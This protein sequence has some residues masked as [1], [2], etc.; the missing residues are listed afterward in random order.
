MKIKF[1]ISILILF[2]ISTKI[3]SQTTWFEKDATWHY[4][5]SSFWEG[6]GYEKMTYSKDT[7]IQGKL[8]YK[9]NRAIKFIS[10]QF[11]DTIQYQLPPQMVHLSGDT[12][13]LYE[14][15][16]FSQLYNF[17]LR[18]GDTVSFMIFPTLQKNKNIVSDIQTIKINNENLKQQTITVYSD[19]EII[20][21]L[22]NVEKLGLTSSPFSFF[23][24]EF[25]FGLQDGPIY[26]FRCYSDKF[27]PTINYSMEDCETLPKIV[28][29]DDKEKETDFLLYPNPCREKLFISNLNQEVDFKIYDIFGKDVINGKTI[30]EIDVNKLQNGLYLLKVSD[31]ILKIFLKL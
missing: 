24:N 22:I 19:N 12:I 11:F 9:L 31:R 29:T 26:N 14:N 2:V 3:I 6:D 25:S 15:N 7:I 1:A 5:Y 10:Y 18:V 30:A 8:C 21:T 13:W 27:T 28:K 4:S 16:S 23:W 17:D 20:T